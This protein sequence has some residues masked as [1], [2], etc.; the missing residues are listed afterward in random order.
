MDKRTESFISYGEAKR[1][2]NN[3]RDIPVKFELAKYKKTLFSWKYTGSA[4]WLL[5]DFVDAAV[6]EDEENR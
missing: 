5:N 3:A 6:K 4:S 2:L 1:M